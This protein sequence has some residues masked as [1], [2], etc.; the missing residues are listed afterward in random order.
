ML[1]SLSQKWL[2]SY[3]LNK[4][5]KKLYQYLQPTSR[6]KVIF[7]FG[8]QRSGTTMLARVIDL[9]PWVN[10]YGEGDP[11]Y[12]YQ[13]NHP[14]NLRLKPDAEL[15]AL[16]ASEKSKFV[17]IKP[18]YESQN[19]IKLLEMFPGSKGIWIFR[20]CKDVVD[21]HINCYKKHDGATYIQDMITPSYPSWKNENIAPD[22]QQYLASFSDKE[23]TT[24][25]GYAFFW[26]ARNSLYFEMQDHSQLLLTNYETLVNN[27]QTEIRRIFDFIGT[28]F[29][30]KYAS[31]IHK[32]SVAKLFPHPIDESVL[33]ACS[34]LTKRLQAALAAKS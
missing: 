17:L 31:I 2:T 10:V 7:I 16:V 9:C 24:A 6:S 14:L 18:L 15:K 3:K 25:T 33:E 1:M 19:A 30:D 4:L 11:P 8:C 29:K 12:F 27:P 5:R 28:P 26:L 13:E 23:L 22:I 32:H 21:S 20:D 34:A